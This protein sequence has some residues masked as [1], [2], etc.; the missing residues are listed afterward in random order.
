VRSSGSH[1]NTRAAARCALIQQLR[2]FAA[3]IFTELFAQC[4]ETGDV[5][6][7]DGST[8]SVVLRLH[9]RL[10]IR[11]VGIPQHD[12]RR[13]VACKELQLQV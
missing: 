13:G 8:K 3:M 5:D 7:A 6:E 11:V 2:A 12:L 1:C 4:G 10:R 9:W